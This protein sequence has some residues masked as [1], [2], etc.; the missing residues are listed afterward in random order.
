MI[1]LLVCS[2]RR[3]NWCVTTFSKLVISGEPALVKNRKRRAAARAAELLVGSW[4]SCPLGHLEA[5]VRA[6]DACRADHR[7]RQH[8]SDRGHEHSTSASMVDARAP[9]AFAACQR[10]TGRRER[11]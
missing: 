4:L 11:E 9:P 7:R 10:S 3:T 5:A 1:E 2:T 6:S 8:V